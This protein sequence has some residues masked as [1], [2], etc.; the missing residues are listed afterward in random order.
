[1]YIITIHLMKEIHKA[2]TLDIPYNTFN[3][4]GKIYEGWQQICLP[5]HT[6]SGQVKE[7][8]K[9]AAISVSSDCECLRRFGDL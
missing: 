6:H 1:M 2:I 8:G 3:G 4:N 5:P 9:A 7:G